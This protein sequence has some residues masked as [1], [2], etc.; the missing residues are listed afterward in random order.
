MAY[1]NLLVPTDGSG[2]SRKAIRAAVALARTIGA[3]ITGIYV[4]AEGVPTVFSGSRLYGSGVVGREYREL[5]KRE[6]R[7][8]LAEVERRAD[9]E[10]VPCRVLRRLAR[11]PWRA[12]LAAARSH[13]CDLIVMG[14]HGRGSVQT[15]L[16]GSQT[17][18]VLAHSKIPV[19]VCR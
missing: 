10:D 7:Q 9:D 3:R 17:A 14:S 6:A 13:G 18:K 11:E 15:L 2:R 5:V 12:I 1:R 16:L 4:I 19:L 8:I